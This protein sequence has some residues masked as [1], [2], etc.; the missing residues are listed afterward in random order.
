MN[1]AVSP[2]PQI[3]Q[4]IKSIKLFEEYLQF[5]YYP[6]FIEGGKSFFDRLKQTV[7]HVLDIDLP[8]VE[9]IDSD[10]VQ[11]LLKFLS[12]IAEIVPFIPNL[13]KLSNQVELS[14]EKLIKYLY[15]LDRADLMILL[16]SGTKGMS[17]MYKTEKVYLDNPNLMFTLS[18]T[19]VNIDTL[20]ETFLYNQIREGHTVNY[21]DKA[22]FFVDNKFTIE[23]G[24]GK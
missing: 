3:I 12:V 21:T 4:R 20:R 9:K 13:S 11:N 1:D 23:V 10:V 5:G 6:F 18:N 22:D 24:G 15:L 19:Q 14:R 17:K 16:K 2:I 8:S 7:N